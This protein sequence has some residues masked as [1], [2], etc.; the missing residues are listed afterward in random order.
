MLVF[1]MTGTGGR[2]M[3][4][5]IAQGFFA[6]VLD[7]TTTELADELVGGVFSAGPD[8]LTAAASPACRRWSRSARSTW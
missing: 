5:L 6:G 4:S 7:L 1:H 2:A 3:E 8:R